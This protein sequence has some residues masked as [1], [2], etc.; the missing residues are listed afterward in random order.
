MADAFES[1]QASLTA[2]AED[3]F[4]VTPHDTNALAKTTR[5]LYIGGAGQ[6]TVIMKSGNTVPFPN[7]PAGFIL[8]ARVT[9]VKSTGTTA[10]N[11]VAMV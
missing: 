3:A 4:A 2:P 7:C 9:H 6:V 5:G 8:P 10:T 11:I 1:Y